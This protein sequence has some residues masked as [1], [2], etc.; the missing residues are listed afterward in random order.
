[1]KKFKNSLLLYKIN[2]NK[3]TI[4][5]VFIFY[6]GFFTFKTESIT[7]DLKNVSLKIVFEFHKNLSDEW[8]R[9]YRV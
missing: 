3:D 9:K 6:I 7:F 4:K 5:C 1:M 8:N 2:P